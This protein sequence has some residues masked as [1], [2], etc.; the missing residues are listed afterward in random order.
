LRTASEIISGT[1]ALIDAAALLS[2]PALKSQISA[3]KTE[4][5]GTDLASAD[6][7]VIDDVTARF[8]V[9]EDNVILAIRKYYN[10]VLKDTTQ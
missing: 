2:E 4:V 8:D 1:G 9:F 5:T 3:A 10:S 7:S 6:Q